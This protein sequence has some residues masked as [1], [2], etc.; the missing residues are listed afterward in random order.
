MKTYTNQA[1]PDYDEELAVRMLYK[2][3]YEALGIECDR[4]EKDDTEC[5][6]H[7]TI[8]V[9][10][11]AHEFILGAPQCNALA[12]FVTHICE[13]NLYFDPSKERSEV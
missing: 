13:E 12:C 11:Y 1:S 7:I 6:D 2:H 10:G 4:L 3:T 8:I 9:G 5:Y